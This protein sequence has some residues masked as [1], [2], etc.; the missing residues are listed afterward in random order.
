MTFD[1][2]CT[3]G[4][5]GLKIAGWGQFFV[6]AAAPPAIVEITSPTKAHP[7][8]LTCAGLTCLMDSNGIS[9]P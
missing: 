3:D 6:Q 4:C 1:I 8:P 5:G 9:C 2:F 7:C